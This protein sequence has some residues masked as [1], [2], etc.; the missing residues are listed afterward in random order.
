MS[1]RNKVFDV[2]GLAKVN[3]TLG[4]RHFNALKIMEW[5][6]VFER[7]LRLKMSDES[8]NRVEV[9]VGDNDVIDIDQEDYGLAIG[10]KNK[11]RGHIGNHETHKQV[12]PNSM[13]ETK[14]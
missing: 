12:K 2:L 8:M 1:L 3:A 6:E 7:K 11:E 9:A 10:V 13:F 4:R 14:S 5:P